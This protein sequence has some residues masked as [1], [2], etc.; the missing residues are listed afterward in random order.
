[1]GTATGVIVVD[2]V[3]GGFGFASTFD[4]VAGTVGSVISGLAGE[5]S[6]FVAGMIGIAGTLAGTVAVGT[7]RTGGV[8]LGT[9]GGAV[10]VDGGEMSGM[11]G[12]GTVASGTLVTGTVVELAFSSLAGLGA[13]VTGLTDSPETGFSSSPGIT[14]VGGKTA[15]STGETDG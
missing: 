10:T 11:L 8:T 14:G 9:T 7:G 5:G 6:A 15:G 4:G 1:M 13:G 3:S 12:T 2:N